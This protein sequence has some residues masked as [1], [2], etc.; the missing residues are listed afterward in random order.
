M[1][2]RACAWSRKRAHGAARVE[3][4]LAHR[5]DRRAESVQ[6][7]DRVDGARHASVEPVQSPYADRLDATAPHVIQHAVEHGPCLRCALGLLVEHRL[8]AASADELLDVVVLV[9]ERLTVARHPQVH[10]CAHRLLLGG[11]EQR[12]DHRGGRRTM[13]HARWHIGAE[14]RRLACAAAS[15]RVCTRRAGRPPLVRGRAP[16]VTPLPGDSRRRGHRPRG[17]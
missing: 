17:A 4:A 2:S 13:W 10:G 12:V 16:G 9:R 3:P 7:E 8:E 6:L 5:E 11:V 1:S 14:A 15:P